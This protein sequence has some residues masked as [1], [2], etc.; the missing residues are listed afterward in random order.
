MYFSLCVLR[1]WPDE[2]SEYWAASGL[3]AN[4]LLSV[5]APLPTIENRAI[6]ES[7]N[8]CQS[9]KC[10]SPSLLGRASPEQRV[11][12]EMA[13]IS[14]DFRGLAAAVATRDEERRGEW[15]GRERHGDWPREL[16]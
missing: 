5:N 14:T 8:L 1:P 3:S 13:Q 4:A 16:S 11:C 9:V 6:V 15:L 10:V 7:F 2:T 12:P